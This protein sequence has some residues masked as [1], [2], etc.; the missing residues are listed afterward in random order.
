MILLVYG[1]KMPMVSVENQREKKRVG[2]Y[3]SKLTSVIQEGNKALGI[4]ILPL[5]TAQKMLD[6][7]TK[8][9]K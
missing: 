8:G 2:I 6:T 5:N 4:Y 3:F 7:F 9:T 1:L